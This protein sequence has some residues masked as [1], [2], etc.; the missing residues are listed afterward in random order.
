MQSATQFVQRT[1]NTLRRFQN[2]QKME[3]TLACGSYFLHFPRV[4]KCSSCFISVIHGLGDFVL[5]LIV[6]GYKFYL[7]SVLFNQIR[8]ALGMD[9]CRLAVVGAAPVTM[10]TLRYFQS[11]NIPLYELFGMS[12]CSGPMTVSVPG[13]VTSGSCGI[14]MDGTEMKIINEDEDG[15]GEV[16]SKE[17]DT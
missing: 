6:L 10:E 13:H 1:A 8:A 11:I 3:K 12:E 17:G 2:T 4:P 14:A 7:F 9:R 16:S 15:N 5:T